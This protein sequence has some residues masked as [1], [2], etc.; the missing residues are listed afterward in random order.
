[1]K[2]ENKATRE[3]IKASKVLLDAIQ[4]AH[5]GDEKGVR[6]SVSSAVKTLGNIQA[7]SDGGGPHLGNPPPPP[8]R[9]SRR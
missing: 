7:I 1:M 6:R 2:S 5:A 8:K 9:K 4:Q 3:I